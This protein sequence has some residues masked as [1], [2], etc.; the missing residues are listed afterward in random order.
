MF[1][2]VLNLLIYQNNYMF[3]NFQGSK[4]AK[5]SDQNTTDF[6]KCLKLITKHEKVTNKQFD[7]VYVLGKL[8]TPPPF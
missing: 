7:V 1:D 6:E 4:I 3:L 2:R 8:K 5:F